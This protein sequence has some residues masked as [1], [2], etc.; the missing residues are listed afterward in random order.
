MA[1][2]QWTYVF[3]I[4]HRMVYYKAAKDL[5]YG[6]VEKERARV[7]KDKG[8]SKAVVVVRLAEMEA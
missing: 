6:D 3:E 5:F 4:N 8:V 1:K 2:K 7:A